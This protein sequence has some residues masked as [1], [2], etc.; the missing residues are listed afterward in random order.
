MT[1]NTTHI[2]ADPARRGSKPC[3]RGQRFTISQLLAEVAECGSV[4]AVACAFD[5]G[6][7]LCCGAIE[8]L[9]ALL[10]RPGK[11]RPLRPPAT[12]AKL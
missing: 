1:V 5:L 11:E 12:V 2:T 3:L 10:D 4:G 6:Y 9:A 7:D 8:D